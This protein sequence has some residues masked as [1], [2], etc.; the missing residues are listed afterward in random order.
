MVRGGNRNEKSDA[1]R[2]AGVLICRSEVPGMSVFAQSF[3]NAPFASSR[4]RKLN[5][6]VVEQSATFIFHYLLFVL[7]SVGQEKEDK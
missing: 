4:Q 3:R 1:I 6:R 5:S 2:T 7:S